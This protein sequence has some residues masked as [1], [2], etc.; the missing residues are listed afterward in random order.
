MPQELLLIDDD[1]LLRRSL[2][3]SLGRVGY[4]VR[5]A[6]TRLGGLALARQYPPDLVLLD[7]GLPGMDGLDALHELRREGTCPSS[8]SPP[9]APSKTKP[10]A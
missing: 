7:I 2:A 3:Y 4:A 6:G 1:P 9:A 10:W 8:S 5:T